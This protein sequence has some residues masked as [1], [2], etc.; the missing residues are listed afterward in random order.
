[1]NNTGCVAAG[2]PPPLSAKH[3]ESFAYYT[4]NT[5]LPS[6]LSH[7]ADGLCRK[8]VKIPEEYGQAASE[9][10]KA[11]IGKLSKLRYEVQTNKPL[12]PLGSDSIDVE[13]WNTELE[14]QTAAHGGEVPKWYTSTWLYV[15]CYM[16]RAL[17]DYV[18]LT[19]SLKSYDIFRDQK[20][21]SYT[22]SEEP[23]RSLLTYLSEVVKS[24]E[25]GAE[26]D[27][28]KLFSKF[29]QVALWGNKC[30]LCMTQ[31]T[32]NS[33]NQCLLEL[34]SHL[35]P[36]ILL[37][38]TVEALA[39]LRNAIATRGT[40]GRVD[41][42]LDNAGF[43][44]VTDLCLGEL[45]LATK[46][47]SH[48]HFHGKAMPWFVSDV[49]ESDF[50][51]TLNTMSA[52]NNLS[53]SHFGVKWKSNLQAGT[54][55]YSTHAF[56]TLPYDFSKMKKYAPVLYSD[57]AQAD[58]VIFKGDLN[59]RKLA[60]DLAWDPTAPFAVSLRGFHPAPLCSLRALKADTVVGLR[61][62]LAEEV[63]EKDVQWQVDGNWAT[64]SFC[65]EKSS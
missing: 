49:T 32:A 13:I 34:L 36:N 10:I 62:G 16:Y 20:Q 30:D 40:A 11:V 21:S 27:V 35:R 59:F 54:F 33:Q 37:D 9:D 12:L 63:K 64:I 65:G 41:I 22:D 29:V 48:V 61:P 19:N 25:N 51:W 57:L 50:L 58:L 23:V 2:L 53:V 31:G 56:W 5:R 39:A 52:T 42:V 43:E 1:M 60:G 15:E 7:I 17:Q 55:S 8:K 38:D 44:L 18:A 4:I 6:T 46:L 28:T 47:A 14:E 24:F 3:K 26:N 45:L